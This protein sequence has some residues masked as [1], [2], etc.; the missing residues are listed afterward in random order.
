[1]NNNFDELILKK[2]A[3]GR[4]RTASM[5]AHGG[6]TSRGTQTGGVHGSRGTHGRGR[7]RWRG[8][9]GNE[10]CLAERRVRAGPLLEARTGCARPRATWL[11]GTQTYAP[12]NGSAHVSSKEGINWVTLLI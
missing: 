10:A 9:H 2:R 6:R 4:V 7:I 12:T 5:G 8:D 11:A 3:W 1:M